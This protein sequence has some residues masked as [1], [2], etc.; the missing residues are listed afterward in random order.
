MGRVKSTSEDLLRYPATGGYDGRPCLHA[1][2]PGGV[3]W[4]AVQMRGVYALV[5]G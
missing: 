3:R 2:V 5:V 4:Q 1:R